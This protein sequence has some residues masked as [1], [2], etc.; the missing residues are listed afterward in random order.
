MQRS[1]SQWILLCVTTG[2]LVVAMTPSAFGQY[3]QGRISVTVLD[4]QKA[5]VPGADLELV[6]QATNETRV[7]VTQSAGT[8]TY[9]N[10]PPGKYKLT[11]SRQGFQR[12]V[13]DVVVQGTKS[14]DI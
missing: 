7:A 13:Y 14:T 11:I 5:V 1:L 9:I 2:L 4:P 6:D 10:L 8:F 12:A 3:T